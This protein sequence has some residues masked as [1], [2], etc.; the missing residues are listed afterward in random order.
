MPSHV[1]LFR[2]CLTSTKEQIDLHLYASDLQKLNYTSP[3]LIQDF[4]AAEHLPVWNTPPEWCTAQGIETIEGTGR[5]LAEQVLQKQSKGKSSP[6]K[7]KVKF[8]SDSDQRDVDTTLSLSR[9]MAQALASHNLR[10]P[11]MDDI[12]YGDSKSLFHPLEGEDSLCQLGIDPSDLGLEIKA[13][14]LILPFPTLNMPTLL[15]RLHEDIGLTYEGKHNLQLDHHGQLMGP[16]NLVVVLAQMA[17]YSHAS[18]LEVPFLPNILPFELYPFIHWIHWMR[19]VLHVGNTRAASRGAVLAQ[20]I[21]SDLQEENTISI[22]IGHDESLDAVATALGVRWVL[23]EPYQGAHIQECDTPPGSALHLQYDS[24][25]RHHRL[26]LSFL[27][28]VYFQTTNQNLRVNTTGILEATPHLRWIDSK[29]DF[30][31]DRV[32]QDDGMLWLPGGPLALEKRVLGV[33]EQDYPGAKECYRAAAGLSNPATSVPPNSHRAFLA[34]GLATIVAVLGMLLLVTCWKR[35]RDIQLTQNYRIRKRLV[36]MRAAT[37]QISDIRGS[38]FF[39][40]IEF[41]D[42]CGLPDASFANQ[43]QKE[44]LQRRLI[45]M[46]SGIYRNVIRFLSVST[47]E[48]QFEEALNILEVSIEAAKRNMST[49]LSLVETGFD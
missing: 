17:F 29:D 6:S 47:P 36:R 1:F 42:S 2:H 7:M 46:T 43:V 40:E 37:P 9:G 22:I 18:N 21:Q 41:N 38:G 11:G 27:Y 19:A 35:R 10:W 30:R 45:L 33:L 12:E 26:G 49:S 24:S 34:V 16:A 13:R 23:P 15:D 3:M 5:W 4:V 39:M 14:F 31:N 8:I 20:R 25:E 44:A 32:N 28:P 48:S